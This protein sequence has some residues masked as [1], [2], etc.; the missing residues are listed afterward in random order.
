VQS[1]II[2][3]D[4]EKKIEFVN[5]LTK[6]AVREKEAGYFA[7][8]IAAPKPAFSY[9]IQNGWVDPSRD[10]LKGAG[11]EW[12]N[13]TH[14]VKASGGDWDVAIV[15]VDAPLITL[16]DINRGVW[17]EQ[18][19]PKSATIFSYAFNNYWHTNYRADQ[20]GEITFRYVMT[21]GASLTP[22]S[23]AR[24]GRAEMTALEKDQVID[25]DK[26]GNPERP[27]RPVPV[28]FLQV[29]AP[30]VVVESWKAA[31]DGRGTIVRLLETGARES[32]AQLQFPMLA[33]QKAWLANA[34]EE[35]EKEIAVTGSS[36]EVLLRPLQIVT[37]RI[38]G[39]F[40]QGKQ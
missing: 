10:M 23:L 4:G 9:E 25:Q 5:R 27:L 3:F 7:F 40:Q 37:V 6:D 12:F 39:Q 11:L 38:V 30:D 34:M 32:R 19:A 36:V 18:F 29:D 26:V 15:P 14:W 24:F 13:V 35:D 28:S 21:S 16:G 22:E 20:G 1:E 31:E 2:L 33:V 17:L 8:P